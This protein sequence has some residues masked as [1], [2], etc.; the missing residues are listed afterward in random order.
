MF[1]EKGLFDIVFLVQCVQGDGG[2]HIFCTLCH[3]CGMLNMIFQQ[4]GSLKIQCDL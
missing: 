1:H 2:Q 3:T 4:I